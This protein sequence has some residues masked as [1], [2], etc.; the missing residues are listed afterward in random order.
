[1]YEEASLEGG[2]ATNAVA[3]GFKAD[4]LNFFYVKSTLTTKKFFFFL[5]FI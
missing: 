4:I 5:L 2:G 1:V 3:R